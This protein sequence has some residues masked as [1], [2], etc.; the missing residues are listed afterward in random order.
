MTGALRHKKYRKRELA[1][2]NKG[3]GK[4]EWCLASNA[5]Y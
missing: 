5:F 4:D 1:S 3:K 2:L